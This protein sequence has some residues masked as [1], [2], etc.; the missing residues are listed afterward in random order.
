MMRL[1]KDKSE[2]VFQYKNIEDIKENVHLYSQILNSTG[3]LCF[4]GAGLDDDGCLDVLEVI[5]KEFKWTPFAKNFNNTR[6]SWKYTQNYD[7]RIE[8][9]P[10]FK[11]GGSSDSLINRWHLEG[12]AKISTQHAA[13]WNMRHFKCDSGLGDTG[14]I[15]MA[16]MVDRL[17][18]EM[19]EFL[20]RCKIIHYP[21]IN[22]KD[23]SGSEISRMFMD[24]VSC[25]DDQIWCADGE[26]DVAC[27]SHDAIQKHPE[28]NCD[29][30]RLC[31]CD[32][33]WGV[34]H[35]LLSVD[36][37]IPTDS[38]LKLFREIQS[39][40]SSQTNL[41]HNQWWH[42]WVEGDFVIPDL[43]VMLH[44]ARAGFQAG[45]REFDGFWCFPNGTPLVPDT[46]RK[47]EIYGTQ[48]TDNN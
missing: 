11:N 9:D 28:L 44:S 17:P 15:N 10:D 23:M 18:G 34:Q 40:L 32:E 26:I 39:W 36:S 47:R 45:E 5:S 33:E 4:R 12:M 31:P 13:G 48:S 37:R 7:Q 38:E 6:S 43:F 27:H 19:F 35:V 25:L 1:I 24:S 21:T 42:E 8:T 30:L 16:I 22:K 3:L 20:K 14:F 29:V 2:Y 41:E 46:F